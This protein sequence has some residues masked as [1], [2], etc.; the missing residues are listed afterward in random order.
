MEHNN[1]AFDYTVAV[2]L[3]VLLSLNN[4]IIQYLYKFFLYL[5]LTNINPH[6]LFH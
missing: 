4:I 1:N 6:P 5:C 2:G 3:P